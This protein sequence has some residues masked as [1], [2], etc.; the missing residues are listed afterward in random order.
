MGSVGVR[1]GV[2][3]GEGG[4]YL[5]GRARFAAAGGR[6]LLMYSWVYCG[7]CTMLM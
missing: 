5:Y 7:G 1:V 2:G 4:R 6:D 3:G